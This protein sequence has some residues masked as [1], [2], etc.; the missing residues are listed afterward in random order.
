MRA[1]FGII[2]SLIFVFA[3]AIASV[4]EDEPLKMMIAALEKFRTTYPQEKIHLHLDKPFYATGDNIWFKAYVVNAESHQ[5]TSLSKVIN[6]ELIDE[7]NVIQQSLRL[8]LRAGVSWGDFQLA[9]TLQE[10]NYRIRAYT[11]YMRNFDEAYFFNQ[12]IQIGNA[13]SSNVVTTV[14]YVYETHESPKV[15]AT[16]NYADMDGNVFAGREVSYDVQL[17]QKNIVKGKAMTDDKGNIHISFPGSLP[18][19]LISGRINTVLEIDK[20]HQVHK[21]VPVRSE[22]KAT[23]IQ[24]FPEGGA[25][26]CGIRSRMAFKATGPD[27]KG[28]NISGYIMDANEKKMCEF[29][30]EHAGMGSFMLQPVNGM[31]YSAIVKFPDGS[32]KK[33]TLPQAQSAGFVLE[34]DNSDTTNLL[35]KI[36]SS[37]SMISAGG[38]VVLVAQS[39]SVV[40][41]VSKNKLDHA[42]FSA[43]IPKSRFPTG[44]L[45]LTL[46]NQQYEPVAERLVFIK[47]QDF[48]N[49]SVNE[50]HASGA[51]EKIKLNMDVKDRSGKPVFGSFSVAVTD[52]ATVQADAFGGNSIVSNLLLTGD[53]KGYVEQPGYYFAGKSPL[54]AYHLDNLMMT[55]GWRRFAWKKILTGNFPALTYDAEDGITISGRVTQNKKPVHGGKVTLVSSQGSLLVMDTVTEADGR[56]AFKNLSFPD[57]THFAV[58]ARTAKGN[59]FVDI[60]LDGI[61][62][63]APAENTNTAETELNVNKKL[64]AYLKSNRERFD[65][66][67]HLHALPKNIALSE[68][69]IIGRRARTIEG[70]SNL[71]GRADEIIT[72]DQLEGCVSLDQCLQGKVA[73]LVIQDSM[74]FLIRS[75]HSSLT[76][77]TPMT[78]I[79]DGTR[80]EPSFLS[81]INP[82]DVEGVEV[83]KGATAAIYGMYGGGGVLIITSKGPKSRIYNTYSGGIVTTMPKGYYKARQFYVPNYSGLYAGGKTADRQTTVYWN[84][85]IIVKD[86]KASFEYFNSD[87]KGT[88]KVTLEGIDANGTLGRYIYDYKVN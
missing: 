5:L 71:A 50:L 72:A 83:L 6:V 66:L 3:I 63:L 82:Q 26:V 70:S 17:G 32:E 77:R 18:G 39:N 38:N 31:Q 65:V 61:A 87:N 22:A 12:T 15:D 74:A 34:A 57:S 7:Q 75:M 52:A 68:V 88:Y 78:V 43:S 56:F 46:F 53:I 80:V 69:K 19:K 62:Q 76:S 30:S 64:S 10:G 42:V 45:Q 20:Q 58:Q 23:D 1:H 85:N 8:P 44:I 54:E 55:Q 40:K 9:D 11:N 2:A 25:S 73:G 67:R 16:I 51:G 60:E 37:P 47:H 35:V 29:K 48:L 27:G 86:G 81:M 24:F 14:N 79:F 49:V 13:I 4:T 59:R 84:P 21:C 28:E 41:F 36:S 33:I